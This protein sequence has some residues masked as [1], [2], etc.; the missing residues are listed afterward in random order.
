MA[1]PTQRRLAFRICATIFAS[2]V[3]LGA[4][5]QCWVLAKLTFGYGPHFIIIAVAFFLG[6]FGLYTIFVAIL[7]WVTIQKEASRIHGWTSLALF[8]AYMAMMVWLAR[9]NP[10]SDPGTFFQILFVAGELAGAW[11]SVRKLNETAI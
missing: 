9:T 8:A 7:S 1:S 10:N 6:A 5:L 2:C 11:L 4:L 3:G